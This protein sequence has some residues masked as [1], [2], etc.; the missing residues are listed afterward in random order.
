[1]PTTKPHVKLILCEE[2]HVWHLDHAAELRAEV[3]NLSQAIEQT[4]RPEVRA[5]RAKLERLQALEAWYT[6]AIDA[7]H[8]DV[9][10]LRAALDDTLQALIG[11]HAMMDTFPETYQNGLYRTS[12]MRQ[13]V[14]EAFETTKTLRQT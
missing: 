11:L 3:E 1:M 8:A 7:L 10:R 14:I 12:A 2:C 13:Q 4:W 5:L 6:E 9:D